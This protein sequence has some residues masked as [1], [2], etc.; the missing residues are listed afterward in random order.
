MW[1]AAWRKRPTG[2]EG[3][4][5][6]G[7][8]EGATMAPVWWARAIDELR[9]AEILLESGQPFSTTAPREDSRVVC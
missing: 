1:S 9:A 3:H 6:A 7:E 2:G 4:F 8:H 5:V